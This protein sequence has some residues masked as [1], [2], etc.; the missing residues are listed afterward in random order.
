MINKVLKMI[1]R[2]TEDYND[3]TGRNFCCHWLWGINYIF[4]SI[5]GEKK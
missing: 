5:L 2:F 3:Y 1:Y 4:D